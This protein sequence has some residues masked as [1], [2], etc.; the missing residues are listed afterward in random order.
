M[1]RQQFVT[2]RYD[3]LKNGRALGV[4]AD[5][6]EVPPPDG[7]MLATDPNA[8]VWGAGVSPYWHIQRFEVHDHFFAILWSRHVVKEGNE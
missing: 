6:P 2:V 8:S 4:C 7:W 3:W 1:Q 5:P